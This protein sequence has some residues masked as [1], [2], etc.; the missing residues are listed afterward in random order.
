M[1]KHSRPFVTIRDLEILRAL[2]LTPLTAA[3]MM[4]LSA[5]WNEPFLSQRTV[6]DRMLR[7]VTCRLVRVWRYSTTFPCQPTNY[8]TL[9]R[10]G[11]QL[12]HGLDA[13]PPSKQHFSEVALSRQPHTQALANFIVHTHV[14]AQAGLIE[15]TG[16]RRENTVRLEVG[17]AALFPDASFE[18]RSE[19]GRRYR[20]F[21]EVDGG[22]ER[23]CTQKAAESI[24]RKIRLYDAFQD[25]TSERFRVLFVVMHGS[26]A[27]LRNI[28]DVAARAVRNPDRSLV[29]GVTLPGYVATL[30]AVT[31]PVFHDH[32]DHDRALVDPTPTQSFAQAETLR[33]PALAC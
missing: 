30:H 31:S 8:Y 3:Q 13:A 9:S 22:T 4:R 33:Q 29:Y 25:A 24:E 17:G 14:A 5:I 16:F 6:R 26:L 10:A 11:Y 2:D 21:V 1:H 32:R 12:L 7:L 18:L 28:L 19:N 15:I 27:R 23:L 20:F